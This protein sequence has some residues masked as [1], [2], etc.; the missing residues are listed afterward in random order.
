MGTMVAVGTAV[1]VGPSLAVAVGGTV[2]VG[3]ANGFAVGV[4]P[5]VAVS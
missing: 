3:E 1:D 4:D 2:D 5:W